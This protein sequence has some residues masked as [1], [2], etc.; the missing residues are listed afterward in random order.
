M[1]ERPGKEV[2]GGMHCFALFNNRVRS[3]VPEVLLL[4]TAAFLGA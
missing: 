3:A 4:L 1:L 2:P